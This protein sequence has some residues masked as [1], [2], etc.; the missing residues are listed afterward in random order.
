MSARLHSC[1]SCDSCSKKYLCHL[2]N[3]CEITMSARLHSCDSC[4]SCSK[5]Y[6]C[7]PW[8]LC[9]IIGRFA[10]NFSK[11]CSKIFN[12]AKARLELFHWALQCTSAPQGEGRRWLG[13]D[14]HGEIESQK[15][16]KDENFNLFVS[17][18]RFVFK[19]ISVKSVLSVWHNHVCAP[20]FVWLSRLAVRAPATS[21]PRPSGLTCTARLADV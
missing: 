13:H 10:Q 7:H 16:E 8:Y 14:K 5:K 12:S 9:E 11:I 19:K 2:C 17:F 4:D 1:H 6:L 21:E 3:L 15:I 18:V 20:S